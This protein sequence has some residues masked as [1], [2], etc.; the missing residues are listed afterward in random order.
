MIGRRECPG[1]EHDGITEVGLCN[2]AHN[3]SADD[4]GELLWH[5]EGRVLHRISLGEAPT[6]F[7]TPLPLTTELDSGTTYALTHHHSMLL[8]TDDVFV[9][10]GATVAGLLVAPGR[11]LSPSRRSRA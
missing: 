6:G 10:L 3:G 9:L 2:W 1:A 7:T 8:P 11:R 5:I 4:P